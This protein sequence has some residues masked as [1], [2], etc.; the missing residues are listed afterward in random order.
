MIIVYLIIGYLLS[1][2]ITAI[3]VVVSESSND[4]SIIYFIDN[5][6]ISYAFAI[7][8][9]GINT[10][11]SIIIVLVLVFYLTFYLIKFIILYLVY[12][13]MFLIYKIRKK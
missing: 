9:P 11:Y 5:L 8:F 13:I 2:C 1:V 3:P 4:E 7:F 12:G 10:I 6:E